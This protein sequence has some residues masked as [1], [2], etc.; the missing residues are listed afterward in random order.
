MPIS[1]KYVS[2]TEAAQMLGLTR[3]QM[4]YHIRR[5]HIKADKVGWN[6]VIAT[7]EIERARGAEWYKAILARRGATA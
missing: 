1:D 5:K 2:R 3:D 7:I 4:I 6:Y